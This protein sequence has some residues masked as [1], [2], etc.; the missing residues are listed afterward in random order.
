MAGLHGAHLCVAQR[1]LSH[2]A[3]A[4]DP[5]TL[6]QQARVQFFEVVVMVAPH[7]VCQLVHQCLTNSLVV[8]EAL[9]YRSNIR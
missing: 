5:H 7:I 4:V 1:R 9:Q 3:D 8:S 2:E 6:T